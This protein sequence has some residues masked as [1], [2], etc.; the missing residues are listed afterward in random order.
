[1]A[2][3]SNHLVSNKKPKLAERLA[4]QPFTPQQDL[5]N[6]L[7]RNMVSPDIDIGKTYYVGE[8][9][10]IIENSNFYIENRDIFYSLSDNSE[11]ATKK[12]SEK[13][14]NSDRVT[15]LVH[16]PSFITSDVV[17][18]SEWNYHNFLKLRVEHDQKKQPIKVGNVVKIQFHQQN[19][20]YFPMV[21]DVVDVSLKN[22]EEKKSQ[23]KDQFNKYLNCRLLAADFIN[24]KGATDY[25]VSIKPYGGYVQAI[26]EIKNAFLPSFIEPFKTTLP[27]KFGKSSEI[28][29][30]LK[31]IAVV[32]EVYAALK[33]FIGSEGIAVFDEDD[34]K[35][36]P[37]QLYLILG[38]EVIIQAKD[39]NLNAELRELF[40][41]YLKQEFMSRL[42]YTFI[43]DKDVS[44][45]DD[46]SVNINAFIS[47]KG[48]PN[49]KD[50]IDKSIKTKSSP[51]YY[52]KIPTPATTPQTIK[53]KSN[54]EK[55][56]NEG[57]TSNSLYPIVF[58]GKKPAVDHDT[59]DRNI[60]KSFYDNKITQEQLNSQSYFLKLINKNN[61]ESLV[62][63]NKSFY[64]NDFKSFDNYGDKNIAS[65]KDIKENLELIQKFINILVENIASNEKTDKKNI[66]IV[67]RQVLKIKKPG[68]VSQGEDPNSRHYYGKA[69]DIAVYLK[70]DDEGG[71]KIQQIRPE[72]VLLYAEKF[73]NRVEDG[74]IELLGHGLFLQQQTKYYNHIEIL[75]LKGQQTTQIKDPK[76]GNYSDLI[77]NQ[78]FFTG[79]ATDIEKRVEESSNKLE[80]LKD[81]IRN[82]KE[83]KNPSPPN[84]LD[85]RF[86]RILT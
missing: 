81:V 53:Q 78:R 6:E 85:E 11:R 80:S 7:I 46:F 8:V 32:S 54:I 55:C 73:R 72:I 70:I 2:R 23:A 27:N 15:L 21:V 35:K 52:F 62:S 48:E 42:G 29:I 39:N 3:T 86:S 17:K 30:Q 79:N 10:K 41:S 49:V 44:T 4:F 75:K 37:E 60:I 25:D 82:S 83:F 14:Y 47:Y 12:T 58:D 16:V 67:P 26:Q 1:M 76:I 63:L 38:K 36:Y 64:T 71:K 65:T 9:L 45:K 74:K 20:L 59:I 34:I 24:Q 56:D 84:N 61:I 22:I 77:Q 19:S 40:Y 13:G 31:T 57:G 43:Y 33:E 18:T 69:F 66:L 28:I 68:P 51:S 5:I 50:Y